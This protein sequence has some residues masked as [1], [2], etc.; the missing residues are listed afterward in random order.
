MARRVTMRLLLSKVSAPGSGTTAAREAVWLDGVDS[1]IPSPIPA[2]NKP[3][4]SRMSQTHRSG[5]H[6]HRRGGAARSAAAN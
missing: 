2:M 5:G 4:T 1:T 3:T 6:R